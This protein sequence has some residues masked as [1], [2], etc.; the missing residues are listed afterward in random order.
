MIPYTWL[1]LSDS[2]LPLGSFAFSSGLESYVAHRA[3]PSSAVGAALPPLPPLPPPLPHFLRLSVHSLASAVLPFVVAAH[4]SSAATATATAADL[5]DVFDA[6]TLC[7]VARRASTAQGRA[8]ITVHDRALRAATTHSDGGAGEAGE[9]EAGDAVERYKLA[10]RKGEASGHFAVAWGLVCSELGLALED[11][12]HVFA[13]NHA[14]AVVSAAVRLGLVGPYQAQ[15][16]L[17]SQETRSLVEAAV[18]VGRR[19]AVEDAGQSVPMLD[20]YQGRHELL[21]SRVFNS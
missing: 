12:L 6:S 13:F 17:A 1:V 19:I 9:A 11:T 15:A 8:L 3:R 5:D 10:V 21:Y 4:G 2:A 7:P 14:K 16:V 20:L 18:D